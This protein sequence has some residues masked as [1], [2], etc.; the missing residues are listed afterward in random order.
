MQLAR[1]NGEEVGAS[2]PTPAVGN[3]IKFITKLLN[4]KSVVEIGTGSGV[5]G[6]W[7]L[8]GISPDG[9]LTTIDSEREH[10][11]IARSIFEEAGISATNIELLLG[12]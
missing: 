10:S 5:G 12:S 4:S 2:D 6:L 11:K 1:R 8:Q 7:I 3:Y 9:V